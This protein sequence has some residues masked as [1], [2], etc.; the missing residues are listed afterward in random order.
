MRS[1]TLC[2]LTLVACAA[3]AQQSVVDTFENG[4]NIGGWINT[5]DGGLTE[6]IVDEGGNPGAFL[7][8]IENTLVPLYRAI[9]PESAF[10]GDYRARGVTEFSIDLRVLDVNF[11]EIG[12]PT[13]LMLA[14][15]PEGVPLDPCCIH[16]KIWGAFIE[17]DL[18]P[19]IE[20]GW[21]TF[22]WEIP[23]ASDDLPPAWQ[24]FEGGG[25]TETPD[26]DTLIEGVHELR[27]YFGTLDDILPFQVWQ[28][29]IDNAAIT[30]DC[31]ADF[32]GD[33]ELTILDFVAFQGA[34]VSGDDAADANADGALNVLDF[35]A[36]QV[37][38]EAGCG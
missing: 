28:T 10:T 34:F 36:F 9:D 13:T 30:F 24:L 23:A 18:V 11:T 29:G 31:P 25:N 20:E 37:W 12:L 27:V 22:T 3:D 17:G 5:G 1:Y 38:F 6:G 14:R 35:I 21:K 4:V 15:A 33:G 7:F 8:E 32:D 16:S 19:K 26:W 2:T